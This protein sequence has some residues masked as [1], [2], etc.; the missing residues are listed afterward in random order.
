M[1]SRP[2]EDLGVIHAS[3]NRENGFPGIVCGAE[4]EYEISFRNS[5]TVCRLW[6]DKTGISLVWGTVQRADPLRL[7]PQG[8]GT[9]TKISFHFMAPYKNMKLDFGNSGNSLKD[10]TGL[11][12]L[13]RDRCSGAPVET[14]GGK[15]C[16]LVQFEAP[17]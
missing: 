2:R 14:F 8:L 10:I 4:S 3:E 1:G 5:M 16:F 15:I 12:S 7:G 13:P 11:R 6:R 17:Y 9:K